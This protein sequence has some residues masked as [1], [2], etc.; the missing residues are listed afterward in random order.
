[1]NAL[2]KIDWYGQFFFGIIMILSIFILFFYGFGFG[3]LILGSWQLISALANTYAFTR[4]GLKKEIRNYWISSV[5]DLLIFFSPFFLK[6]IFDEDDLEVLVWTGATLGVPIAIY[7]LRIYKKLIM[8]VD[9][10][11]ELTGFTKHNNI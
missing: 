1:M 5:T 2:R 9:L 4:N 6:N 3:L 11:N 10:S 7:Y 8:Y